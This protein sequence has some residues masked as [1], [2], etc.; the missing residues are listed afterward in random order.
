MRKPEEKVEADERQWDAGLF[1]RRQSL[2]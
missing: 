1:S 2:G